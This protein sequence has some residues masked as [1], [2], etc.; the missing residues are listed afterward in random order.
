MKAGQR[1]SEGNPREE[2][3]CHLIKNIL[4]PGLT[5]RSFITIICI[6]DITVFVLFDVFTVASGLS[7]NPTY[8]L[9]PDRT[10]YMWFNKD[11]ACIK[12]NFEVW[13]FLTPVFFHVGFSHLI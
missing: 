5:L 12:C 11:P 7:L 9:G 2:T 13:R 8:F 4:A 1:W 3:F 6:V 10:V